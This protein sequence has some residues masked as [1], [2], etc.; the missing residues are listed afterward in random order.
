M[1]I[2]YSEV[3]SVTLSPLSKHIYKLMKFNHLVLSIHI[4]F[5]SLLFSFVSFYRQLL[6]PKLLMSCPSQTQPSMKTFQIPWPDVNF[7]PLKLILRNAFSPFCSVNSITVIFMYIFW[8]S[9]GFISIVLY[10]HSFYSIV[11][12][13]SVH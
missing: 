8:P 9:H 7:S 13:V 2:L 1:R 3:S 5:T 11:Y 10:P 12:Q 6:Y 4:L